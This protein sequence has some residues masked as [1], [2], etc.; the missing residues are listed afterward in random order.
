MSDRIQLILR[1]ENGSEIDYTICAHDHELG[2]DWIQAL[3][4]IIRL[5]LPLNKTF[6]FLG[7]PNT[8][9]DLD[10]LCSKLNKAIYTINTYDW[11]QHGLAE[12]E[13][14][15]HFSP[16]AVRFGP[17][18]PGGSDYG[19]SRHLGLKHEILNRLHNHFEKLQGTVEKES[20][21]HR[22][23]NPVLR[24]AIGVLNT[25]CHEI[26]SLVLSQRK[27]AL[28][29]E[30][31]RPSQINTFIRAPRHD[32]KTSHR[33]LFKQ[34]GYDKVFGGVYMHWAQIGKTLFEV[35]RDEHAPDIDATTCEAITH[36]KYYSGEFDIE[37]GKTLTRKTFDWHDQQLA[38]FD[39]WL[40]QCGFDP[41]NQ[42]LS[43]GYLPIGQ[44]ELESSF[45]TSDPQEVW[46]ILEQYLDV[47][48]INCNGAKRVYDYTWRDQDV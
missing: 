33:Q 11:Q 29:P 42:D 31:V 43:L 36:L 24:K 28:L 2:A 6:C 13:I 9:R 20:N 35:F 17:E 5:G 41:D 44:V 46:K 34:N 15:E 22:A 25:T 4:Q 21:Y 40:R 30:W 16:D 39:V 19:T 47:H 14:E 45:G 37:W 26:E 23:A 7:F 38:E 18:Y 32:L 10:Y 48:V 1:N 3:E 8:P 12:Y 27:Q